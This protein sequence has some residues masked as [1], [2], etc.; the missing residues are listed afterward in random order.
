MIISDI[1]YLFR[2]NLNSSAAT[3]SFIVWTERNVVEKWP[4]II[5]PISFIR[6]RLDSTLGKSNRDFQSCNQSKFVLKAS[7]WNSANWWWKEIQI[8][9]ICWIMNKSVWTK[10]IWLSKSKISKKIIFFSCI[11]YRLWIITYDQLFFEF[12]L[13]SLETDIFKQISLKDNEVSLFFRI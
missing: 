5:W 13:N 1:W 9:D 8:V 3:K 2:R 4:S 11:N 10:N 6:S 7:I 12:L